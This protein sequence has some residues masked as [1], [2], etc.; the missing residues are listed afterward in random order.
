M[1]GLRFPGGGVDIPTRDPKC[2]AERPL[3]E[4]LGGLVQL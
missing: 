3:P 1:M 2:P 4:D